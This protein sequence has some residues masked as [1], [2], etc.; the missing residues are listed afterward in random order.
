MRP[1]AKLFG[2][3]CRRVSFFTQLEKLH[4]PELGASRVLSRVFTA[5]SG[6]R[7][8]ETSFTAAF[9][10]RIGGVADTSSTLP[11][12][13]Q[14]TSIRKKPAIIANTV[15]IIYV[16]LFSVVTAMFTVFIP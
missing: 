6:A 2:R 15:H 13:Q 3:R 10:N 4:K 7:S 16:N 14:R 1:D 5:L 8:L 9:L 12:D 11:L